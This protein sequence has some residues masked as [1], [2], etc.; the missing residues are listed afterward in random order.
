MKK[1]LLVCF[2][3]V[4]SATW[5][6]AQQEEV[7]DNSNNPNAPEIKFEEDIYD[8][9]T[10]PYAGNGV[11]D[12][13]FTNAGKEPLII[14]KAQGSCGCTVPKWPKEPIMAGQSNIINVSYDTKRQGPFTK[15]VTITSNAKTASKTITIKGVVM[16]QEET[17]N[18]SPVRKNSMMTPLE[19]PTKNQ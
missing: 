9:G 19:T 8:F 7:K 1:I 6:L 14:S 11:H 10:I 5:S 15:T 18:Q 16:S 12:F 4:A 2:T 3:L 17:E 13:K